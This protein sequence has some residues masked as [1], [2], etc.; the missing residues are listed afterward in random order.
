MTQ[1]HHIGHY[2]AHT[3]FKPA[4]VNATTGESL[5]YAELDAR[6]NRFARFLFR[7][8]LRRGDHIAVMMENNLRILDVVWAALRS[9]L[10]VT[11]VNRFLT[12]DEA[13]YVLSDCDARAVV[14]SF[15]MRLLA[16]QVSE[17]LPYCEHR[18]MTG[19]C[20]PGWDS[21]E[22][23]IA[24][25]PGTPLAEQWLGS[26]MLYSSGTTGRPKG[27]LRVAGERRLEEGPEPGRRMTLSRHGFDETSVGMTAA[28]LYHA[29]A[30][31]AVLNLHFCGGTAVFME[32]F[33]AEQALATIE[34]YRVTH[35][36]WVPTMFIRMLKLDPVVRAR[37][38]L[39]SQRCAIHAAAPCPVEV[40]QRMIAW[41]G[42][43]F[44]SSTAQPNSTATPPSTA[45]RRSNGR[46][47][48]AKP[49][50]A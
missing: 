34:R 41:W 38:D 16:G 27:I 15:D 36:N 18:L 49:R 35:S 43:S 39:S 22:D 17:R 24:G 42:R 10:H 26:T 50:W 3:P 1:Y 7:Q 2:A 46:A 23:A 45:A 6:S 31:G 8:G 37:Y 48:L 32:K 47:R 14:S 30:L 5:S 9:G 33:D 28:P 19:G 11:A 21:Y 44:A 40:K 4:I 12:P 13:V 29:A 25:E 20:I